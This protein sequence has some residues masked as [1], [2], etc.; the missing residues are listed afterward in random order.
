VNQVYFWSKIRKTGSNYVPSRSLPQE[1]IADIIRQNVVD[2]TDLE[3]AAEE[4]LEISG[5]A[6]YVAK[7]NPVDRGYFKEHMRLYVDIY[8]RDCPFEVTTTNRYDIL[9]NEASIT[10]RTLISKGEVIKYLAGT[11]VII[12]AGEEKRIEDACL[13]KS[14]TLSARKGDAC[15]FLGPARFSN[16]DCDSN[17]RLDYNANSM[18]II[19]RKDIEVG[20]EITVDYG[21]GFFGDENSECLCATCEKLLRKGWDPERI[22]DDGET[23]RESVVKT[24]EGRTRSRRSRKGDTQSPTTPNTEPRVTRSAILRGLKQDESSPP[25]DPLMPR[26]DRKHGLRPNP[27]PNSVRLYPSS[28]R[29]KEELDREV[30][31]ASDTPTISMKRSRPADTPTTAEPPNK[32]RRLHHGASGGGRNSDD[33]AEI[34][35]TEPSQDQSLPYGLRSRARNEPVPAQQTSGYELR[36]RSGKR[37]RSSQRTNEYELR[38][39]AGNRSPSNQQTRE[40]C[41]VTSLKNETISPKKGQIFSANGKRMS[42][43]HIRP[44]S[45]SLELFDVPDSE[46]ESNRI[47]KRRES[48]SFHTSPSSRAESRNRSLPPATH[49]PTSQLPAPVQDSGSSSSDTDLGD[50]FSPQE[51]P[52]TRASS[53]DDEL[54]PISL[55]PK[56]SYRQKMHQRLLQVEKQGSAGQDTLDEPTPKPE[57]R[58]RSET[59]SREKCEILEAVYMVHRRDEMGFPWNPEM[60]FPWDRSAKEEQQTTDSLPQLQLKSPTTEST[61]MILRKRKKT[62]TAGDAEHQGFTPDRERGRE[63]SPHREGLTTPS[64]DMLVA[65]VTT[66]EVKLDGSRYPKDYETSDKLLTTPHHRWA[67]CRTCEKDFLAY[68]TFTKRECPRC[69][70]HSKLY[71][72]AWPK[73]DREDRFDKE[74]RV[75]NI[76]AAK[77]YIPKRE[78]TEKAREKRREWVKKRREDAAEE[79]QK[80]Q[81]GEWNEARM[82][83]TSGR[84]ERSQSRARI[85]EPRRSNSRARMPERGRSS[86]RAR[87]PESKRGNSRSRAKTPDSRRSNSRS[88]AK[89]SD[90]EARTP[91]R[92][93]RS[94]VRGRTPGRRDDEDTDMSE[95]DTQTVASDI[96]HF[97]RSEWGSPSNSNTSTPRRVVTR[98][99]G[100]GK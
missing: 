83:M 66:A 40:S 30:Q 5:I 84:R 34:Q 90:S 12:P 26:H 55:T 56:L 16:H 53:P 49:L 18:R 62:Y 87:V 96:S 23:T 58:T 8:R 3:L 57:P 88:R 1:D 25:E 9:T 35:G 86:S 63:V 76:P 68:E 72:Y 78:D 20:Q 67:D 71:G 61:P 81:Q 27:T 54:V 36:S 19:A 94:R 80:L 13:V 77:R 70:R 69:E 31:V 11:K 65:P 28:G 60:G 75:W 42:K 32:K 21:P 79:K 47:R 98:A 51:T 74:Q 64:S 93:G 44:R 24:V 97:H 2:Q 39:Q 99:S 73:T 4:V 89:T 92:R 6:K 82:R 91:F 46:E 45:A 17:A 43:E 29:C 10:A 48:S 38:S 85:P 59:K 50:V 22:K 100:I 14:I 95:D 33:E 52:S 41:P 7:L 37:S 15:L